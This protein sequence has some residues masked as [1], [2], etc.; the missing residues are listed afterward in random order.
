MDT[1]EV[2]RRILLDALMEAKGAGRSVSYSRNKTHYPGMRRYKG[3]LY[4]YDKVVPA[5]DRL[6]TQGLLEHAVAPSGGPCGWQSTLWAAPPLLALAVPEDIDYDAAETIRLRQ[7]KKLAAYSSRMERP[8]ALRKKL[9]PI[10]EALAATSIVLPPAPGVTTR[11]AI[12]E[13]D[14]GKKGPVVAN[15]SQG[16]LHRVFNEDFSHGGRFYGGWWLGLPGEYRR[17]L[18]I[19]DEP[20]VEV[21]YSALHA[22]LAYERAGV[23]P[24]HADMYE[25]PGWD[26]QVC[27]VAFQILLNAKTYQAAVGAVARLL[28]G[29]EEDVTPLKPLAHELI[30]ATKQKHHAIARLFHRGLGLRFQYQDS[31][32]AER[33]MRA[34]V[35]RGV[36]VLGVHDSFLVPIRHQGALQEEMVKAARWAGISGNEDKLMKIKANSQYP[37]TS[38]R[39]PGPGGARPGGVA[40]L[41]PETWVHDF[42]FGETNFVALETF[43]GGLMSRRQAQ[44]VKDFRRQYGMTQARMAQEIGVSRPQLAN[45]EQGRFGLGEVAGEKL[46]ALVKGRK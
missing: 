26:R 18:L 8:A 20:V 24:F 13:I 40:V 10:N 38:G 15:T 3:V 41:A 33:V 43:R 11:G 29:D 39:E 37:L 25:L 19:D 4:T 28:A 36:P 45:A 30:T 21:D 34:L 9:R 27:K 35:S 1:T 17:M 42:L 22:N 32:M 12:V 5:I 23:S 16:Q 6:A 7:G 2:E 44:A 14:R 31:Q 46:S